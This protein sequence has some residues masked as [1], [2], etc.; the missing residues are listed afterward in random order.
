M[1]LNELINK[2]ETLRDEAP[3]NGDL[4][5]C[6]NDWGEEYRSPT[7]VPDPVLEQGPVTVGYFDG[8][9]FVEVALPAAVFVI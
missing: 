2:L 3:G 1:T 6:A 8:E 9:R 5:V 7:L 4:P